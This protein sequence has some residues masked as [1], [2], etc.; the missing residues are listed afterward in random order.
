MSKASDFQRLIEQH[1]QTVTLESFSAYASGDY[2]DANWNAPD[3]EDDDYPASGTTPGPS[4]GAAQSVTAFIQ[5][6]KIRE[7]GERLVRTPW[8]EEVE[9]LLRAYFP[10]ETTIT[11]RDRVTYDGTAYW[12]AKIEEWQ[13]GSTLVYRLAH[14]TQEVT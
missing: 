12:I 3:P 13:E 7:G 11:H 5:P 9:A 6:I 2:V 4:Y 10:A 1:G 8:G 14:L